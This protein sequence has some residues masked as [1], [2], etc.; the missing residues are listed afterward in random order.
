[1]TIKV[2]KENHV[3]LAVDFA[4]PGWIESWCGKKLMMRERVEQLPIP[5]S[6]QGF[7]LDCISKLNDRV[8]S[9]P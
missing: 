3:L 8:L 4:A 2:D 7:C 9:C 5:D 1:M 6:G